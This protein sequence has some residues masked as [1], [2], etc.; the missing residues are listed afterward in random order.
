MNEKQVMFKNHVVFPSS[1][2][3]VDND[4]GNAKYYLL[5]FFHCLVEKLMA[6]S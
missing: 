5:P 4:L 1:H 2:L 6:I 3:L